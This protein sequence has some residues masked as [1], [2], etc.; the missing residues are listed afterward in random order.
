MIKFA[1]FLFRR[2]PRRKLVFSSSDD[3]ANDSP[4]SIPSGTS[5][6]T[7][8]NT[9]EIRI[10]FFISVHILRQEHHSI[11]QDEQWVF[12]FAALSVSFTWTAID[13]VRLDLW[14]T[15]EW[16]S[17]VECSFDRWHCFFQ[18][19]FLFSH[20]SATSVDLFSPLS[21]SHTHAIT[22]KCQLSCHVLYS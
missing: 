13:F 10:L 4:Q 21:L 2:T 18:K 5:S 1:R 16:H 12:L 22:D 7:G 6:Q 8:Q 17:S 15:I 9:F 20:L 19:I 14:L 3:E 11:F